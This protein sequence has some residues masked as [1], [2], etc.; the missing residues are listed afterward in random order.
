VRE[1]NRI[2]QKIIE[3][4]E[5][6]NWAQFHDPKNIA[7]AISIEAAELLEIFLWV[8]TEG[9][10]KISHRKVEM[11]KEELADIFIFSTYLCSEFG[12]DLLTEVENKINLN[13]KKYPVE[14]SKGSSKKYN[15]LDKEL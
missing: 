9:S 11:V 7:E 2:V 10:R 8:N 14:K 12:I 5:D 3:F 1:F 15:E 6:R 4:R 13:S